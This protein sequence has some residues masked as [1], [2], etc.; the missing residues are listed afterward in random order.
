M[1]IIS[2][3]LFFAFFY[4]FFAL[5]YYYIFSL[6]LAYSAVVDNNGKVPILRPKVRLENKRSFVLE[7]EK[8]SLILMVKCLSYNRV[9]SENKYI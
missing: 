2:V 3:V 5:F 1:T 6:F 7:Q 8:V 9:K 4:Y